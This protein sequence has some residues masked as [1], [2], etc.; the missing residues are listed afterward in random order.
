M[1]M[2]LPIPSRF[3]SLPWPILPLPMC[4]LQKG[5][6]KSGLAQILM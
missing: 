3:R 2:P 4:V 1:T 5:K 6:A